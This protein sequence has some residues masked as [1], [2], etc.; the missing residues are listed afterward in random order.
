MSVMVSEERMWQTKLTVDA[1]EIAKPGTVLEVGYPYGREDLLGLWG[2]EV[3]TVDPHGESA[4]FKVRFEDFVA[5]HQYDLIN[6]TSVLDYLDDPMAGLRNACGV[7][8][9][10]LVQGRLNTYSHPHF[11]TMYWTPTRRWVSEKL[12]EV[13]GIENPQWVRFFGTQMFSV[14]GKVQR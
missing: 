7:A 6:L 12:C 10:V 14:F 8:D 11:A 5:P 9:W 3:D 1:R 2:A 4:T 13:L